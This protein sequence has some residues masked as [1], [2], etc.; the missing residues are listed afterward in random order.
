MQS[1]GLIVDD[2]YIDLRLWIGRCGKFL[3]S[4]RF[5]YVSPYRLGYVSVPADPGG[6]GTEMSR[7][8]RPVHASVCS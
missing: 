7:F 8:D 4:L 6:I 5:P 1:N 3:V 2:D